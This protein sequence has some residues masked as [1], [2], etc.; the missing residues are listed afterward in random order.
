MIKFLGTSVINAF[1]V[2]LGVVGVF[3]AGLLVPLI[4]GVKEAEEANALA[5]ISLAVFFGT[6]HGLKWAKIVIEMDTK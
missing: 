5:F 4:A 6:W 2:A 1:G 3:F